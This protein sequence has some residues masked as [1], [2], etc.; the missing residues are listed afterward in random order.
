MAWTGSRIWD[1]QERNYPGT[2][3]GIRR[4]ILEDVR[5]WICGN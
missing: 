5:R 4:Q 2:E 1:I 3:L